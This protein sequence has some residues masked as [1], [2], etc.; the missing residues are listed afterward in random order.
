MPSFK[1]LIF[2]TQRIISVIRREAP[3]L[4]FLLPFVWGQIIGY[5]VVACYESYGLLVTIEVIAFIAVVCVARHRF[6]SSAFL[7]GV[8]SMAL[9]LYVPKGVRIAEGPKQ[10]I[11]VADPRFPR[12]GA[13]E[14]VFRIASIEGVISNRYARCRAVALPWRNITDIYL[15]QTITAQATLIPIKLPFNPFAFDATQRRHGISFACKISLATQPFGDAHK[16]LSSLRQQVRSHIMQ[17]F[18]AGELPGLFLSMVLGVRDTIS[19]KTSH[20]FQMTGLSHLLVVSG[21]HI[22]LIFSSILF[23]FRYSA[24]K[25]CAR[26]PDILLLGFSVAC[27]S[28]LCFVAFVGIDGASLRAGVAAIVVVIGKIL[29]RG[30]GMLSNVA[31]ALFIIAIIWPGCYFEPG[32]QL[33]FAALLGIAYGLG[34]RTQKRW[35]RGLA[36]AVF[37][38][39]MTLG[40]TI[41]W[42]GILSPASFILNPLLAALVSFVVTVGG[43]IALLAMLT[44]LDPSAIL[45]SAIIE[46]L[47]YFRAFVLICAELP[48]AAL[49]VEGRSQLIFGVSAIII[50]LVL[51]IERALRSAIG[52]GVLKIK[53]K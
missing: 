44:G 16:G 31:L 52:Y 47:D 8:L 27:A 18:G 39:V 23:L 34:I 4:F 12:P 28:A 11:L 30:G 37:P 1:Q 33:T 6:P 21:F 3:L 49:I 40:L 2:I 13:M 51:W 19:Q 24:R 26:Q 45:V 32:V 10:L 29:E 50:P 22:T 9:V 42:F 35:L 7:V 36:V 43:L 5:E 46:L 48:Y 14:G 20:A 25:L 17:R 15:G 38:S 41:L 53:L